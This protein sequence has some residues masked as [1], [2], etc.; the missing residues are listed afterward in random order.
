[1]CRP[2]LAMPHFTE[3]DTTSSSGKLL[4]S[5]FGSGGNATFDY[6][7]VGGGTAGLVV[8]TRLAEDPNTS[9]A[10]IEAGN[11]YE[12]SNGIYSQVPLFGP[13]GSGKSPYDTAPLVDWQFVTEPQEGML[14]AKVHYARG[15]C[16]GGS[17]ARNYLTYHVGAK[18]SYERWANQTGDDDYRLE[19]FMKYFKKS[20][21]FVG[22]NGRPANATPEYD[23]STLSTGGLLTVTY[24]RYAMAFSSWAQRALQAI[25]VQPINGLTSGNLLGSSYQLLTEDATEFVRETSETAFLKKLGLTQSNL[26]VYQSTL[27]TKITFNGTTASGVEIDMGGFPFTLTAN[28]EVVLSAGAFQ[29]PQLL[30]VSGIGPN[31]TLERF[32]IPVVKNLPGVGQNM[33]DHILG[34]PSYRVNVVTTSTA[35]TGAT[36]AEAMKQY[37]TS[38]SGILTGVG[39]DFLAWEKLPKNLTSQMPPSVQSDLASLPAGWPDIEFFP[40]SAYYGYQENFLSDSPTD[41]Y[42]YA[43]VAVALAAPFSRGNVSIA[44][45]SMADAPLINPNWLTHPTDQAV[46]VAGYKRARQVFAHMG[47]ITIGDE[48]FPGPALGVRSDEEILAFA[49]KSFGTVFHASCTCRMGKEE[50]DQDAVVDSKARVFG[51]EGLRVV[52]AS[53]FALLP[54]GHPQA[55]IYAL[56]EKIADDIKNGA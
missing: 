38:R 48:Y 52:D 21:N 32:G 36:A 35:S 45:A 27:A 51:V 6:I 54:P 43:T 3:R 46:V 34:G 23:E 50:G 7:V 29:S 2:L 5:S 31:D 16:L 41:G 10:V 1:M 47:N 53:S 15:K 22:P 40:T 4:G 13:L 56:A 26:V 14:G 55:T 39:A 33:E 11:F 18:D 30:M 28:K 44:S 25:G 9:V 37:L 49:R 12:I 17:S 20:Q 24:P 42:N 19:N 8:A